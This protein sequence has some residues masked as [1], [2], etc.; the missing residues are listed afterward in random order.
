MSRERVLSVTLMVMGVL[1]FIG[2]VVWFW[3]GYRAGRSD[4]YSEFNQALPFGTGFIGL[5]LAAAGAST[6]PG[7]P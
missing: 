5:L 7:D 6:Y 1:M 4:P 2:A 3:L